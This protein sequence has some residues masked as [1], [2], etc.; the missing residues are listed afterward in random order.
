MP[1]KESEL[2]DFL[3]PEEF[4][5]LKRTSVWHP[6]LGVHVGALLDKS[7]YKSLHCFMRD[8]NCIDTE[9]TA[10]AQNIDGALREWFNHGEEKFEEQRQL[11]KEVATRAG[12]AHICTGLDTTYDDRVD[13]WKSKYVTP[14]TLNPAQF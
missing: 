7:I 3:P 11:M 1:D 2:L 5:F 14:G 10:C 4:E 6:K 9:E 8:K 12:I 13:E